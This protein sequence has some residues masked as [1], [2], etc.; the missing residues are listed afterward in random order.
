MVGRRPIRTEASS[1]GGVDLIG[2]KILV[3]VGTEWSENLHRRR[4]KGSLTMQ[5]SQGLVDPNQVRN[6]RSWE[7][8]TG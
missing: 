6:S 3:V 5:I 2:M 1:R 4:G 7:R 8:E